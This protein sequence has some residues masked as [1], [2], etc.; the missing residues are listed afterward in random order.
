M[1]PSILALMIPILALM[2]PIIAI[3]LKHQKEMAEMMRDD[4]RAFAD[5]RVDALQGQIAE[6]KDLVH[7]QTISLDRM[8]TPLPRAE[9][10]ERL[11]GS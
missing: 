11:N 7:Q 6:L 9:V 10:Q 5:A 4:R 1:S 2:I 3:L 8:G